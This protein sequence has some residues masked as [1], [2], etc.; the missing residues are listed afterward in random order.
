MTNKSVK[1]LDDGFVNL[2]RMSG[3]LAKL[4]AAMIER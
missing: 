1:V 4:V 2:V 3:D